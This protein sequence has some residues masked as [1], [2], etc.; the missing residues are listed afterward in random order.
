MFDI[1]EIRNQALVRCAKT[2]QRR[3]RSHLKLK[4]VSHPFAS[5]GDLTTIYLTLLSNSTKSGFK[6][7]VVG[8]VR[9][10]RRALAFK[11]RKGSV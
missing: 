7:D 5:S 9:S 3:Q 10:P 4:A 2:K 11:L 8:A 1:G 6:K